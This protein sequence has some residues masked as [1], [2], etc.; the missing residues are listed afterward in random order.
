MDTTEEQRAD[1]VRRL[2]AAGCVFAEDEASI[3]LTEAGT[4]PRLQ[5][6]LRRRV[7]GE[8][9]EYVVGWADFCG[10]RI[11]VAPGV[12]VPRRRTTT[13]VT[14]A[15]ELVREWATTDPSPPVVVDLCCGSGAI[16]RVLAEWSGAI[17]LHAADI[18]PAAVECARRN[19]AGYPGAVVHQGDLLDALPRGLRGRI[20]VLTANTPYVPHDVIASM[21]AEARDHEPRITLDGGADGLDVQRRLAGEVTAW[22]SPGGH[23]LVETSEDQQPVASAVFASHGLEVDGVFD[24]EHGGTVVVGTKP[25]A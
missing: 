4:P 6:M 16:A 10:R 7:A 13:L 14:R 19:L 18:D 3:L 17:E 21:P 24:A 23:V 5:S 11:H 22:L 12:F 8:P 1:V 15:A 25:T 20:S 2:R 9:L